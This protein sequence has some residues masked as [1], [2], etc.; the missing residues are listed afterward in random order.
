MDIPE[1][2]PVCG[3]KDLRRDLFFPGAERIR[4]SVGAS[5]IRLVYGVC[6]YIIYILETTTENRLLE[7]SLLEDKGLHQIIEAAAPGPL[8]REDTVAVG[9]STMG[10]G[11]RIYSIPMVRS[12]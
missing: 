2:P 1:L 12:P 7:S 8:S 6:S 11:A 9:I 10:L 5:M 3:R 4:G